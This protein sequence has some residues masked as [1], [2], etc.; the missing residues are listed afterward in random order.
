MAGAVTAAAAAGIVATTQSSGL[1][2]KVRGQSPDDSQLE[3]SS[4]ESTNTFSYLLKRIT[5]SSH[6]EVCDGTR[7]EDGS[8]CNATPEV[9]CRDFLNKFKDKLQKNSGAYGLF[10]DSQH[11][12]MVCCYEWDHQHGGFEIFDKHGNHL[13]ERGCDDLGEDPCQYTESRGKHAQPNSATHKPRS[14]LCSQH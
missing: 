13:G 12:K 11:R 10:K 5:S 9:C 2:N 4:T 7:K 1:L 14:Q 8:S 6:H 3:Q